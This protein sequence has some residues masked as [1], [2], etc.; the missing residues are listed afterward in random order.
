MSKPKRSHVPDRASVP[1]LEPLA[2]H[3]MAVQDWGH[4]PHTTVAR[5][6]LEPTVRSLEKIPGLEAHAARLDEAARLALDLV[7]SNSP[8]EH[9]ARA[10]H[11]AGRIALEA[12][13]RLPSP[14]QQHEKFHTTWHRR[15]DAARFKWGRRT[16]DPELGEWGPLRIPTWNQALAE[17]NARWGR[18]KEKQEADNKERMQKYPGSSPEPIH[19]TRGEIGKDEFE[20]LHDEWYRKQEMTPPRYPSG[21]PKGGD[22]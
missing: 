4:E 20:R 6:F 8:G 21:A 16:F 2:S 15:L 18:T 3:L 17:F 5:D 14:P 13:N 7:A 1:L 10:C 12:L 19:E 9:V 11:V 22:T